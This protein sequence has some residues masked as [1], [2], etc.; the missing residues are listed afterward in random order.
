MNIEQILEMMKNEI[1]AIEEVSSEYLVSQGNNNGFEKLVPKIVDKVKQEISDSD[2]LEK[3]VHL[4]H[5]FPDMDLILNGE[6]YGLELKSRNN[7]SWDT[8]GNSVFESIS[9][10]EY[11]EIYVFFGT[12]KKPEPKIKIKY[13]P[14]WQTT[15]NIMVTHS[16]RFKISMDT[17]ESVFKNADEYNSLRNMT[18][19]QKISFLQEYL[20]NNTKGVKWFVPQSEDSL[21][22]I[23][24]KSLNKE[25]QGRTLAEVLILFPQDHIKD[26]KGKSHDKYLRS[27]EYLIGTYYY[28]AT[29]FRDFFSSGKKYIY[30]DVHFPKFVANLNEHSEEIHEILIHANSAFQTLAYQSWEEMGVQLSM[31]SFENDYKA[32]LDTIGDQYLKDE[33]QKANV[34]K[35]SDFLVSQ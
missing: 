12:N 25:E 30:N 7:G 10:E 28:Y 23:L 22:P 33:L 2:V 8:N 31:T 24:I 16:P 27:A 35:L 4:G 13:R 29:N 3:K 14:Y 21:S 34:K 26:G 32:I 11:K 18:E 9:D 1:E 17:T 5:H 6:R 20:R 19:G 15:S